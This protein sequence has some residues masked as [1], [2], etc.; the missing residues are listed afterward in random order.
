V[1]QSV[2]KRAKQQEQPKQTVS[3]RQSLTI[4]ANIGEHF[5]IQYFCISVFQCYR[6]GAGGLWTDDNGSLARGNG[7]GNA[8]RNRIPSTI[9]CPEITL[10]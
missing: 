5:S 10:L 1:G 4:C 8:N 6:G 2:Q 7:D 9:I 3:L